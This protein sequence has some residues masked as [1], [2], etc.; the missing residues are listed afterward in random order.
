MAQKGLP[1]NLVSIYSHMHA[2]MLTHAHAPN[3]ETTGEVLVPKGA[4]QLGS[5]PPLPS[6]TT[7]YLMQIN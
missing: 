4:A 3:A 1:V 6:P 5:P 2:H 7:A